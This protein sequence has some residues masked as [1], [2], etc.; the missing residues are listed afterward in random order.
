[1]DETQM[2]TLAK[3]NGLPIKITTNPNDKLTEE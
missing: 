2:R 3:L 1:M